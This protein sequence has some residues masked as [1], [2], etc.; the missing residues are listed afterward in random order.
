RGRRIWPPKRQARQNRADGI[1]PGSGAGGSARQK[2]K[3]ANAGQTAPSTAPERGKWGGG[4]PSTPRPATR[5]PGR[6]RSRGDRVGVGA[7]P[8]PED[9]A[10]KTPSSAK[11]SRRD[12]VRIRT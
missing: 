11:Q 4:R 7:A 3:L 9:L 8:E 6:T 2:A 12:R 1:E 10:A 5:E